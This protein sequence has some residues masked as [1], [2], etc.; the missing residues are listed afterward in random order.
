MSNPNVDLQPGD[1]IRTNEGHF[2]YRLE[3]SGYA[4]DFVWASSDEE[5]RSLLGE[6][7]LTVC[8]RGWSTSQTWRPVS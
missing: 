1:R 8:C 3:E 2:A 4:G 5:A 6:G 7:T